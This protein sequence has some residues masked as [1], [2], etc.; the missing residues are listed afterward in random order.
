M[1]IFKKNSTRRYLYFAPVNIIKEI[2]LRKPPNQSI[3][4][5]KLENSDLKNCDLNGY[6]AKKCLL[7]VFLLPQNMVLHSFLYSY[8]WHNHCSDL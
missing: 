4:I 1:I 5:Y 3:N 6:H 7:I 8:F 2:V